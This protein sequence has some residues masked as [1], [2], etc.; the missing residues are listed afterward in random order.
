MIK[1]YRDQSNWPYRGGG[2]YIVP[3]HHEKTEST[4][5]D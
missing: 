4:R 1:L 3:W 5:H 2:A